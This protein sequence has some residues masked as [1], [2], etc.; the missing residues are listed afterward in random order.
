MKISPVSRLLAI[1]FISSF[2]LVATTF[3]DV[4]T[5]K[6]NDD[7]PADGMLTV[8]SEV[9]ESTKDFQVSAGTPIVGAD[10][11]ASQLMNLITGTR[12]TIEVDPGPANVAKKITVLPDASQQVP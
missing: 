10:G 5:G 9:D 1:A 2:A 4:Y 6:V 11:K 8:T 7:D 3:A 12:V